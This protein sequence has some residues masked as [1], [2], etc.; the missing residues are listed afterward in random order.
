MDVNSNEY[1]EKMGLSEEEINIMNDNNVD[2]SEEENIEENDNNNE[3]I[4]DNEEENNNNEKISN[5]NETEEEAIDR[6]ANKFNSYEELE[7]SIISLKEKLNI[8]DDIDLEELSELGKLKYYKKLESKIGSKNKEENEEKEKLNNG[9]TEDIKITEDI[10][11]FKDSDMDDKDK[12]SFNSYANEYIKNNGSISE[13]TRKDI[14]EKYNVPDI[15]IDEYLSNLD[16][17]VKSNLKNENDRKS[18]EIVNSIYKNVAPQEEMSKVLKWGE[19]NLSDYQ[20]ELFNKELSSNDK[21]KALEAAKELKNLFE[22]NNVK[23]PVRKINGNTNKN[24]SKDK[25][26]SNVEMLKD[27]GSVEYKRDPKFRAKVEK[28]IANSN[29]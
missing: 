3:E 27:L 13:E 14:K 10:D 12:E 25:Y 17:K 4:I 19:N 1:Y 2:N 18:Y 9:E 11:F 26:N 6:I 20:I 15:I 7:N 5:E 16:F 24:V 29:L 21:N 23:K 8:E 22:K 28:K